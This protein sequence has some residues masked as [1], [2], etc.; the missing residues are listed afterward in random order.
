[1][2]PLDGVERFTEVLVAVNEAL[3]LDWDPATFGSLGAE[4][5]RIPRATAEDALIAALAGG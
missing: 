5:T 3:G 2:L 4:T 1:M